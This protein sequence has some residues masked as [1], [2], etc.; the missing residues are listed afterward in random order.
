[1]IKRSNSTKTRWENVHLELLDLVHIDVC[2]PMSIP[3]RRGYSYLIIFIDDYFRLGYVYLMKYKFEPYEFFKE[4]KAE[5]E[6]QTTK[7]ITALRSD[8]ES[9][10]LGHEFLD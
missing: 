2:S 1:M 3:A 10:Y 6:K 4:Y 5:V 8:R 7:N 9:E